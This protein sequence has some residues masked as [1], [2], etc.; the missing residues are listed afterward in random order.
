[1]EEQQSQKSGLRSDGQ[2]ED[3]AR[4]G[5][6]AIPPSKPVS[7]AFGKHDDDEANVDR[8]DTEASLR[9]NTKLGGQMS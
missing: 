1:M 6:D 8:T 9:H 4:Q 2:K 3:R 5:Y 7:G